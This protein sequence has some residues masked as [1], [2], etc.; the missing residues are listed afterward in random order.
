[1]KMVLSISSTKYK[2]MKSNSI[3]KRSYTMAKWI[4][5]RNARVVQH[6]KIS[7]RHHINRTEEKLIGSAQL[8]QKRHLTKSSVLS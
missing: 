5:C 6:K 4:Y 2:Q 7:V 3:L 8:M 1:M